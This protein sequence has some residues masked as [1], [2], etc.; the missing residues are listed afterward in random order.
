MGILCELLE[1]L[2][3]HNI[4][5]NKKIESTSRRRKQTRNRHRRQRRC[6]D[7]E[8]HENDHAVD[9]SSGDVTRSCDRYNNSN[10]KDGAVVI[11]GTGEVRSFDSSQK[12]S[13]GSSTSKVDRPVLRPY[14][15]LSSLVSFIGELRQSIETE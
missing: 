15:R 7:R 11:R 3:D 4:E 2:R 5:G 1:V 10:K 13:T 9:N 8:T 14:R 12:W 6:R